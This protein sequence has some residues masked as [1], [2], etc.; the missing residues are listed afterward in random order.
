MTD[1]NIDEIQP[2]AILA[3]SVSS[4]SGNLL[5][6]AGTQLSR[7][8]LLML[9]AH[10]IDQIRILDAP[11]QTSENPPSFEAP[12]DQQPHLLELFRH[13]NVNHPFIKT[14]IRLCELRVG[15]LSAGAC[16][17]DH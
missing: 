17:H 13:N 8:H 14:L 6:E 16:R 11:G 2:G 4:T 9:K 12:L 3:A 1:K 10:G 15:H 7:K 5:L